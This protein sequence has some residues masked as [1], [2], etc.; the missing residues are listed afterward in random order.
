MQIHRGPDGHGVNAVECSSCHQD[1]NLAGLH[2]PPGAPDWHLPSPAMPM[3]W[4]GLTDHQLCELF[5]DPQRNGHRTP[6]QIVEHM[7]TPL[8]LWGWTPGDGRNPVPIP[9]HEF[10]EKIQEWSEK[11]AAC[12]ADASATTSQT[13]GSLVI[14]RVEKVKASQLSQDAGQVLLPLGHN[15]QFPQSQLIELT[16]E[17]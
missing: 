12:P 9:Q 11:G 5:K 6:A 16:P 15:G 8:V 10:L 2:M 14:A 7:H 17:P 4:E 13:F 3:I 1:H